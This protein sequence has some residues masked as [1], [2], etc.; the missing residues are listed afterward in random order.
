[1]ISS[2][3]QH[4]GHKCIARLL[5]GLSLIA[6]LPGST[7]SAAE[8]L[9]DD[10]AALGASPTAALVPEPLQPLSLDMEVEVRPRL[11]RL[12]VRATLTFQAH[13][14]VEE[15]R[16]LLRPEI[17][18]DLVADASGMLLPYE[19]TANSVLIRTS[20]LDPGTATTWTFRYTLQLNS[21]LEE[22]GSFYT[23]NPWYPYLSHPGA[24]TEFPRYMPT[25]A[26]LT[27]SLPTPWVAVS[28]GRLTISREGPKN[29][30][31]W[32]QSRPSPF[33]ALVIGRFKLVEHRA[34]HLRGH[35]F[36]SPENAGQGKVFIEYVTSVLRFY[37]K[38]IEEY[39]LT[40]YSL[41]ELPLPAGLRGL[42]WP[43]LTLLSSADVVPTSPFPYRILAHE[44]AHNWWNFIVVFP[45]RSDYWLREGLPTYCAL[46]FLERQYSRAMMRQ[47]LGRSRR[48]ALS[49]DDPEPLSAGF[50]MSS[51]AALF[52]LNYHKSAVVLHMLRTILG[53]DSFVELLR[54][55]CSAYAGGTATTADFRRLAE[56]RYGGDLQWFFSS[57]IEEVA[58]PSFKIRYWVRRRPT[59][60]VPAYEL[61]GTIVQTGA[62]IRGPAL[63]RVR[64]RGAPPLEHTIWLEPGTTPFSLS[65]PSI[66]E[67]LEFDPDQS[68]L[69][70]D[71]NVELV[72]RISQRQSATVADKPPRNDRR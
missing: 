31:L 51:Q 60:Q 55:F 52:S 53:R 24:A 25:T 10:S 59:V 41:V 33:H 4:S 62:R 7:P 17:E 30:Y 29:R 26:R 63:L 18:L 43:G 36:F 40:D 49:V 3:R 19:R 44:I 38:T 1:M 6:T 14:P 11:P 16:L 57:W 66:P 37:G 21:P 2:H 35:G 27:V 56:E 69:S 70:R 22:L 71:V 8:A 15:A 23:R 28:A 45:G 12:R 50:D 5:A 54:E 34:D 72:A 42:T 65:C 20:R 32:E 61:A 58:V 48:L 39:R 9:T 47:E 64:L 68:L 13:R 46:L 67:T